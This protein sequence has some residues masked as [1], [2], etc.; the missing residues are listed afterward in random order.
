M[1]ETLTRA[2]RRHRSLTYA[3][4]AQRA[5]LRQAHPDGAVDCVCER[6]VWYFEK[7][8][9]SLH[10]HHCA[11]CHPKARERGVRARVARFMARHENPPPR[12]FANPRWAG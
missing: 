2:L 9:I 6:S 10:R 5:H 4:R 8:K 1:A 7:R 3:R 12:W 11:S